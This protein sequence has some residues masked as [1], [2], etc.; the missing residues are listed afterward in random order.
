MNLNF[1]QEI[2]NINLKNTEIIN[3]SLKFQSPLSLRGGLGGTPLF[4]LYR[5]VS[6]NRVWFLEVLDP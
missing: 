4:G 1:L 2:S 5:Y 3:G 6:Q